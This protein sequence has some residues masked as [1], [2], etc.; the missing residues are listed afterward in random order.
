MSLT[1]E[2]RRRIER[3]LNALPRHFYQPLAPV[4]WSGFTTPEQLTL[5]QASQHVLQSVLAGTPWGA[6]WEY[7]WFHTAFKL[8]SEAAGKR[9]AL[10]P[11]VG[12]EGIVFVNHKAAGARDREHKEITLSMQG[13]AGAEFDVWVESYAGHGPAPEGGGPVSYGTQSV[14]EPGPTQ[15]TV[16]TSSV[17]IWYEEVYQLWI[18]VK[19]LYEIRAL[20]DE[21]SLRVAEIDEGLRKFTL[22]VDFEIPPEQMLDTIRQA[23]L[24]LTPLMDCTNGSSAPTL[25]TFG[26]AHLDVAWLWP[27]A[28][29]ERKIGRTTSSQLALMKEYPEY[30]YLQSQPHLLDMLRQRYPDLYDQVKTAAKNGQVITEGGMWVEADTNLAGGESLIRQFIYGKRF[31]K[32]EFDTDSELLWLPDVFGYSGALPQIMSGCGIKYFA[33]SKIFWTYNGGDPFPYNLFT[34]EGIDGS[35]VLAHIFNDYGSETRPEALNRRWNERVQKDGLSSLIVAFGHGDGGGG[36]TRDHLEFLRRAKNLE[37]N[38]KT[39][40]ASPIDFF[41]DAEAKGIPSARYVGE[42]YFQAH[43]GTY[44]SQARTKKNTRKVEFALREAEFWGAVAANEGKFQF[45]RQQMLDNWQTVLLLQFHDILPGSSINRVYQEAETMHGGVIRSAQVIAEA[46]KQSI[47]GTENGVTIFNSLSWDRKALVELPESSDVFVDF[48][49]K[50]LLSQNKAGKTCVEVKVPS[51]GWTTIFPKPRGT[52]IDPDPSSEVVCASV[53]KL[54]NEYLR[55]E[56]NSAGE[57]TSIFDKEAKREIADGPCNSFKL[58]KDVPGWFDAWD[59]DSMYEDMPLAID[60]QAK[61]ELVAEGPLVAVLRLTRKIN[62][63]TLQQEISLRRGSRVVEFDTRVDWQESH[64]LLKVAFPVNLRANEALHEIQ[65]GHIARPNHRS[66]PFDANRFEVSNHKWSAL[67]EATHGFAILND[68]KYGLNVL[69]NS[70]NLT[71]LKSALSP[72]MTADKGPQTFKYAIYAWN[73]SIADSDLVENAYELNVPATLQT[74]N[75]GEKSLFRVDQPNV[76]IETVKPAEDGSGDIIMRLYESLRTATQAEL[77][78]CF[79]LRSV[80][81]TDMLEKAHDVIAFE[82][83]RVK[84]SF[85]PFEVKTLRLQLNQ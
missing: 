20:V 1:L 69:D 67:V 29:T 45:P 24:M 36:P 35:T 34:W 28:E 65:F 4:E 33:T 54:E 26:H 82:E 14:P 48:D 38:P 17:G 62:K 50:E 3:W 31:F 44:T 9:I 37:G 49:G 59:I 8:P 68:C 78:T 52:Q 6:K 11:D 47:G 51:C 85:R 66:R 71:L 61:V 79:S 41:K 60:P 12:G 39:R 55:L 76:I 57:I 84:L 63:S 70:I 58:Y 40:M 21:N 80:Q 19:T 23:R 75:A 25:Y 15:V 53:N 74:G 5:D 32:E 13:E 73:G 43:R 83:G 81:E 46:A 18:D 56:L 64:K 16:G 42:L 22:L 30:R 10:R 7:G 77:V 2:W 72:D 27:L